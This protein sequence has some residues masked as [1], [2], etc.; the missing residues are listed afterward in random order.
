[1]LQTTFINLRTLSF[2]FMMATV[3]MIGTMVPVHQA[4]A[5]EATV[6]QRTAM[7]EQ[8]SMLMELI[9]QLMAQ[10]QVMQNLSMIKIKHCA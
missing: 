6:E 1:M 3:L 9:T 2:A 10:M 8:I 7:L 4:A 5:Q